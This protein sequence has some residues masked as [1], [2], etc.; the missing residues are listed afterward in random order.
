MNE[1]AIITSI[2]DTVMCFADSQAY[3]RYLYRTR[4]WDRKAIRK[5]RR[6][7]GICRRMIVEKVRQAMAQQ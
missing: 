5:A 1:D 7:R 4:D 2:M 3:L 6:G